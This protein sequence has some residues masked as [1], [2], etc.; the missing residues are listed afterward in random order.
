MR[1]GDGRQVEPQRLQDFLDA[2]TEPET[3]LQ[4]AGRVE[5]DALRAA[6]HGDQRRDALP[7][8]RHDLDRIARQRGNPFCALGVDR[9]LA[10]QIAIFLELHAAAAGRDDDRLGAALDLG[11]P[12]IDV[13]AH[14]RLRLVGRGEM[15]ADRAATARAR[16][17]DKRDADT[18][19]YPRHRS[20]DGR[21]QR[22]L[23]AAVKGEHPAR[24][25][26]AGPRGSRSRVGNLR[27]QPRWQQR[28]RQTA[29]RDRQRH[30]GT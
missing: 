25:A 7:F 24:V 10:Q 3:M 20:V 16:S 27:C 21:R 18:I 5:G 22:G 9:I 4:R 12:G 2:T 17:P 1:I 19:E 13:G 30:E 15:L 8:G 26:R 14:E 23:D 11:P 29:S 28:P 6:V